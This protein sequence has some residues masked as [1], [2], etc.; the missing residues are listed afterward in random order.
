MIC[1]FSILGSDDT[2]IY[3]VASDV[4]QFQPSITIVPYNLIDVLWWRNEGMEMYVC[5]PWTWR[6]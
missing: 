4:T 1:I 5:K 6:N 3:N 2:R